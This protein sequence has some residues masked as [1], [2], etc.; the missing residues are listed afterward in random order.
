MVVV[1]IEKSDLLNLVG[2]SLSDDDLED[3]LFKLKCEATISG[4]NIICEINPDRLD[5]VSV[6]GIARAMK[7]YLGLPLKKY[8]LQDSKLS[9]SGESQLRPAFLAAVIEGVEMSDQLVKSLMQIQEK[10]HATLGRNRAKVAIG[11]HDLDKIKGPVEYMDADAVETSFIPLQDSRTM[12]LNEILEK[13]PKGKDYAH[14]LT[15]NKYPVFFDKEGPISFPPII[16][17]ERTKVTEHTKN[18]FVDITGTDKKAVEQALNILLCNVAERMGTLKTVR[19]NRE[20]IPKLEEK[21]IMIEKEEPN[22]ILGLELDEAGIKRCLDRMLYTVGIK[23]GRIIINVPVYRADILNNADIIEDVAIGYGYNNMEAVLPNL[24]TIGSLSKKEILTRK[25]RE[26]MIGEGFQEFL[27]FVLTNKENNFD[28]MSTSGQCVEILNPV[29]SEYSSLR[30]WLAPS[31]MKSLA[32]NMHVEYPQKIFEVG[33]IVDLD[34]V[35]VRKLAG[36]VSHDNANLTEV[37]S[38]VESVLREIGLKYDI[39]SFKHP[40][41]IDTRCGEIFIQG[42]AIGYFGEVHTRVLENWKLERPVIIF[43]ISLEGLYG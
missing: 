33:D 42:K 28:K 35:P 22:K 41:F 2:Q 14:L 38:L 27:N 21:T 11:V 40:S 32:A 15:G 23:G 31:L 10:L 3:L 34:T 16:N 30:T 1:E 26:I 18:L 9:L 4:E 7:G 12:N 20:K 36:A 8:E 43:E 5:M 39:K 37:K 29:S 24:A 6:E 17:S 13:H 19:I 25:V